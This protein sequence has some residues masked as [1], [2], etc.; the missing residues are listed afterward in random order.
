MRLK[1]VGFLML[2]LLEGCVTPRCFQHVML[3]QTTP[4][5]FQSVQENF[6]KGCHVSP[7]GGTMTDAL[8]V[9]PEYICPSCGKPVTV[10]YVATYPAT[11]CYRCTHCSYHHD[12]QKRIAPTT[13][14]KTP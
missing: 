1:I 5:G 14:K 7:A 12:L 4:L 13:E 2:L 8:Y 11:T 10:S 3:D 6:A 9:E